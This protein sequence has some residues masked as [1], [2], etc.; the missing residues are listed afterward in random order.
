MS[1]LSSIDIHSYDHYI[2]SFSGGKDSTAC[3]L[4]L[5]GQGVPLNKIELWHQNIDG[6]GQ[7][8]FDWEVTPDY[9]RK[10]AE[11]FGVKI[12]FQWKK[13]G[14]KRELLRNNSLTSPTCF[15]TIEGDIKEAGGTRGK[16][17][18]RLKFPQ[19]SPDLKVRW[20]SSYLKIDVCS[21][22]IRNQE[23][24]NNKRTLVLSGERGEESPQ[25]ARYNIFE[26]DKSDARNSKNK[27]HV[28]RL[29]PIRDWKE[30]EVW[31]IIEKYRIRVHPCYYMGWGRCSCKFCIFG[32]SNQFASVAY[33]SP[34]QFENIVQLETDF[35][36]T[37]NRKCGLKVL[38]KSGTIYTAITDELIK[39]AVSHTYTLPIIL[40]N[41][42][43]W[44]IP[45]GAFGENC[46]AA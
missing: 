34:E 10:F 21:I 6:D 36:C 3:F 25:R 2:V 26:P 41:N 4:W 22:S 30:A 37:I 28:D 17:S 16:L 1:G 27:R 33:V 18:T 44:Q 19:Q 20:C 31:A 13:G 11:A 9:C 40:P 43:N 23:R 42:E 12:F 8:F 14:F 15:E 45:A 7:Q 35:D 24:F 39:I 46:G 5:L 29:R 38:I 32:N